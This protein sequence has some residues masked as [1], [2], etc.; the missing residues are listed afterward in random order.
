VLLDGQ[1][2][3]FE[4][5]GFEKDLSIDCAY[6]EVRREYVGFSSDGEIIGGTGLFGQRETTPGGGAEGYRAKPCGC[7]GGPSVVLL[8]CVSDITEGVFA[9]ILLDAAG[10]LRSEGGEV[11]GVSGV[12]VIGFE[13]DERFGDIAKGDDRACGVGGGE[14]DV[15][16]DRSGRRTGSRVGSDGRDAVGLLVDYTDSNDAEVNAIQLTLKGRFLCGGLRFGDGGC[17]GQQQAKRDSPGTRR[18]MQIQ[19]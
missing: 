7:K 3:G 4:V 19:H 1:V 18:A 15:G 6:T 10:G 8:A 16:W 2:V 14:I 13:A 11:L 9:C 17:G 5:G 12:D